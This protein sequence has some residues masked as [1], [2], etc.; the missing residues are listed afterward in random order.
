MEMYDLVIVGAGPAGLNAAIN[1]ASEM[2]RVLMID[3]GNRDKSG[4]HTRQLGGQIIGSTL[5]ENYAG[6]PQGISGCQLMA[7]FEE[8]AIKLG[9]EVICPQRVNSISMVDRGVKRLTTKEGNEF[10]AKTIILSSGL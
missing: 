10:F 6:F 5:I 3:S 4:Q 7:L 2:N 8:Q 9:T 1:G